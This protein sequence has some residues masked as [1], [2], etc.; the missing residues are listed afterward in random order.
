MNLH[1]SDLQDGVRTAAAD[2]S[3]E[4]SYSSSATL[5][6]TILFEIC[7]YIHSIEYNAL[8]GNETNQMA[9]NMY[10]VMFSLSKSKTDKVKIV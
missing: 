6:K 4:E 1:R 5:G 9:V 8:Y 3:L 10:L 2:I 7:A